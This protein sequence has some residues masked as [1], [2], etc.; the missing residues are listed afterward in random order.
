MLSSSVPG[1]SVAASAASAAAGASGGDD[2]VIS[3]SNECVAV[4]ELLFYPS[5]VGIEQ[6]GLGAVVVESVSA[7]AEYMQALL[8]E[9]IIVLGGSSQFSGLIERL[10]NEIRQCAPDEYRIRIRRSNEPLTTAWCGGSCLSIDPSFSNV[11][12]TKREY[13][14]W[15]H[16]IFL[17]KFG[18]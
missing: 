11:S 8:Y 18:G 2:V 16:S 1:S 12:V 14:E 4:P 17:Q 3:M 7:C 5:D 10:E 13:D 6:G 9:H 15:G